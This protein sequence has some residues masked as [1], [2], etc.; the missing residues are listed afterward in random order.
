MRTLTHP[1]IEQIAAKVAAI[2]ESRA[3]GD[4]ADP[5]TWEKAAGGLCRVAVGYDHG[6]KEIGACYSQ[7][8]CEGP[9]ECVAVVAAGSYKRPAHLARVLIHELSHAVC[10]HYD[11]SVFLDAPWEAIAYTYQAGENIARAVERHF[12]GAFGHGWL[13]THGWYWR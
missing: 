7:L 5:D 6:G 9:A 12:L 3:D 4:P 1:E 2:L 13:P 10:R 11:P 8:W